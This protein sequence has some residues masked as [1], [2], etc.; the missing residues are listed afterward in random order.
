ME[1]IL[2]SFSEPL[3]YLITFLT[4][5]AE[6]GIAPFFFL[7]GDSLLF[8]LGLFARQGIISINIIIPTIIIAG[9]LGNLIG[10]YL[11]SVVRDKHHT[12]SLLKKIPERHIVRTEKFYQEYGSWTILFSR[13]IPVV[14][15][16]APFLAGV[17][18]MN[19]KNFILLSAVGAVI[20][21][22]IVTLI[23]F[24]F[25]SYISPQ[26]VGYVGLALMVGASVI[27]PVIVFISHRLFKKG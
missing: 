17:S 25:G 22:A 2:T 9:F 11:G 27:V 18:K 8:S 20:W 12:S 16:I 13:F 7:P 1:Q 15:T 4:V 3:I 26:Y 24:L 23:G 21:G 10:Y 19:Y 5:V 6:T 14:R